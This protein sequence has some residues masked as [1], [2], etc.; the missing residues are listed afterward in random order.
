MSEFYTSSQGTEQ[1]TEYVH[2]KPYT[3]KYRAQFIITHTH[4]TYTHALH[5]QTLHTHTTHTYSH[6]T[7]IRTHYTHTHLDILSTPNRMLRSDAIRIEWGYGVEGRCAC[8]RICYLCRVVWG[9]V[10]GER[11]EG[12][13]GNGMRNDEE[14]G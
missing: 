6:Y 9:D 11:W 12:R 13:G 4:T 14:M 8:A 5:T 7:H 2:N 3:H 10:G 1:H